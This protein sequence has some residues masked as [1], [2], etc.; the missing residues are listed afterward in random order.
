MVR[1]DLFDNC[2]RRTMQTLID[3]IQYAFEDVSFPGAEHLTHSF[4]EEADALIN[5]FRDK[6]D[7]TVLKP[8][9]LNQAPDGWGTAL[10][11]FSGEALRFY[12]PAYLIADIEGTLECAD[13]TSR[14]C[15]F[16]TPQLENRKI[17]KIFGGGT[18]GEH[19]RADFE[20][21][22]AKQVSVI[23]DYLWWKLKCGS[24][25]P[26]IEHALEYYWLERIVELNGSRE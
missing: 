1:L 12:L 18:L 24:Y 11:F 23:V 16:V 5:D 15:A 26:T 14:L 7:W 8:E 3:K 21:F 22:D 9:F 19:A 2:A 17:A 10:S 4:G 13:A 6:T 25:Q 20:L